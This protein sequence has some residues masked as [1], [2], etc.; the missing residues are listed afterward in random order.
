[1]C[2]IKGELYEIGKWGVIVYDE[3]KLLAG[4]TELANHLSRNNT[5]HEYK[6]T[7]EE[8]LIT[9]LKKVKAVYD[10]SDGNNPESLAV[11]LLRDIRTSQEKNSRLQKVLHHDTLCLFLATHLLQLGPHFRYRT[12]FSV[13]WLAKSI[14]VC[15]GLY[16]SWMKMRT[17]ILKKLGS[18]GKFPSYATVAKLLDQAEAGDDAAIKRI[19]DLRESIQK[20]PK[21]ADVAH[22]SMWAQVMEPINN[23]AKVAFAEVVDSIGEMSTTYVSRL[24]VYRQNVIK[25]LQDAWN[26]TANDNLED[27]EILAHLDRVVAR[28]VLHLTPEDGKQKAPEPLLGGF[29]MNY[30]WTSFTKL[31]EGIGEVCRWFETLVD[32]Y[33]MLH[34]KTH[35][36]DD[37]TSVMM[38]NICKDPRFAT[39]A[40]TNCQK[41]M[42]IIWDHRRTL[43]L[44]LTNCMTDD[45]QVL[46]ARPKDKKALESA[47]ENLPE[48]EIFASEALTKVLHSKR[49]K[50][51]SSSRDLAME[52]Q[53]IAGMMALHTTSW[54]WQSSAIKNAARDIEPCM[55]AIA[56]ER[57]YMAGYRPK[58][59]RDK[60][61][62][63]LRR[64][65]E[66][67]L[68]AGVKKVQT[69]DSGGKLRT[70]Q[71]WV[72]W[73]GLKLGES[74]MDPKC[75][76]QG[77][78]DSLV[79]KQRQT[80]E[81][82]RLER[83]DREAIEKLIVYVTNMACA[84]SS[85][86][87]HSL[88]SADVAHPLEA[89]IEGIML[90]AGRGRVRTLNQD[91]NMVFDLREND[92]DLGINLPPSFLDP[93]T[94][95]Y[96]PASDE[97][98][99]EPVE[100]PAPKNKKK[101]KARAVDDQPTPVLE[102]QKQ[103]QKEPARSKSAAPTDVIQQPLAAAAET[104][105]APSSANA[106]K[107][108]S[109][110]PKPRPILRKQRQPS[111]PALDD[112]IE[113]IDR[114]GEL[115]VIDRPDGLT[116]NDIIIADED[117]PTPRRP[118]I[119]LSDAN[120]GLD[121]TSHDKETPNAPAQATVASADGATVSLG[122]SAQD[123]VLSAAAHIVPPRS[124]APATV[125]TEG[126]S[127]DLPD[128]F[129][130]AIMPYTSSPA[131][132]PH[133][134]TTDDTAWFDPDAGDHD[135][136]DAIGSNEAE[137]EDEY[138]QSESRTTD[139]DDPRDETYE[140][141]QPLT[142]LP[143]PPRKLERRV[144]SAA[145]NK[146]SRAATGAF[147]CLHRASSSSSTHGHGNSHKQKKKA[148][149]VRGSDDDDEE[150]QTIVPGV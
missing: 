105:D 1:M 55:K 63:A 26:L 42:N 94:T 135:M 84:R 33:R 97:E 114:P 2:A 107:T 48:G 64:L 82:L 142:Q 19:A 57:T 113:V 73:D 29:M 8:V 148:K 79:V 128:L 30:A 86:N 117:S 90:N 110:K 78:K 108:S 104:S 145:P 11:Q 61:V 16:L 139:H 101:A 129:T 115:E 134:F 59:L 3:D 17:S 98:D 51:E 39:H 58:L 7:E 99:V 53:S 38:L 147:I 60:Y 120:Q 71:E 80:Q 49:T 35:T 21:D 83:M 132:I 47:F 45:K 130:G 81:R 96:G 62:G 136:D 91:P 95:G 121:A 76:L 112:E 131:G 5:L 100:E 37:W 43:M 74:Q 13:T 27:N 41:V 123:T 85:P 119:P 102:T 69:I 44:R 31:Q 32:Y 143:L 10:N 138:S 68:A 40:D 140:P 122:S 109:G 126:Q 72:W 124:S 14:N 75:V 66:M 144:H 149:V 12:E 141:T 20:S 65:I 56:V 77:I 111:P 9:L 89:L 146:R 15:M 88:L 87:P 18:K 50:H 92:Y 67:A 22:L 70:K 54:D 52:S 127:E 24:S 6:E 25:T 23:H 36:M 106:Q 93:A 103:Q 150:D 28:T 125:P 137:D 116:H 4:G 118:A 34:P 133:G 46:S